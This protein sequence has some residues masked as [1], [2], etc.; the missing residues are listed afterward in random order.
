MAITQGQLSASTAA[1]YTVANGTKPKVIT[2]DWWHNTDAAT[3]YGIDV[4]IV[5]AGGSAT[6]TNQIAESSA[7]TID[8]YGSVEL[9]MKGLRL[10]VGDAI[11]ARSTTANLVSYTLIL[12]DT[13]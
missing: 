11:H 6:T 8:A 12:Q 5:A 9:D 1:I 7:T 10:D 13:D 2:N 3:A 4:H